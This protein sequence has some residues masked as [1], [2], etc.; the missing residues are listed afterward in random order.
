[1]EL[2]TVHLGLN[3]QEIYWLISYED[4]L[5]CDVFW[6]MQQRGIVSNTWAQLAEYIAHLTDREEMKYRMVAKSKLK[7]QAYFSQYKR[8]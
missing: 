3:G 5:V 1:M 4:L 8:D 6:L 2:P 7:D